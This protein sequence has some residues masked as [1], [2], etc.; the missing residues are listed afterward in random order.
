MKKPLIG[1]VLGA[2]A[3]FI[4]GNISWMVLSWHEWNIKRLPE[5]QL[6]TDTL[7]TV[8]EEPGFYTFPSY[9]TETGRMDQKEWIEKYKKGPVGM[10]AYAPI[11]G[12]PMGANK[13][14]VFIGINLLTAAVAMMVLL[15]SRD[16]VKSCIQRVLLITS[17]G[18]VVWLSGHVPYSNWF[19]FPWSY[20]F[21]Y[22]F[23]NLITFF[24]L[25]LTLSVFVPKAENS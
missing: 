9:K 5:E 6:I 20:T 3:M 23:D 22:L 12:N 10:M 8:V 2:L 25:G 16:R 24:I 11:G 14:L 18:L 4:W 13:F 17:L 7:K 19:H 1:I 21:V 15:A